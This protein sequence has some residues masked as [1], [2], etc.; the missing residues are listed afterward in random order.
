M[1][2]ALGLGLPPLHAVAAGT[3]PDER[4]IAAVIEAIQHSNL[5]AVKQ[6]TAGWDAEAINVETRGGKTLLHWTV[7]QCFVRGGYV[8]AG[9]KPPDLKQMRRDAGLILDYLLAQGADPGARDGRGYTP[10]LLA[11]QYAASGNDPG[12]SV[13]RKLKQQGGNANAV[14]YE[15][16]N[17]LHLYAQMSAQ[18]KLYNRV[19]EV[20]QAQGKATGPA[21][22]L[23]PAPAIEPI[24]STLLDMG[25]DINAANTRGQTPLM[26]AIQGAGQEIV[27][28][29]LEHGADAKS[30]DKQGMTTLHLL[31]GP[32]MSFLLASGD[33][34]RERQEIMELLL[35]AGADVNVKDRRGYTPL[36]YL[37]ESAMRMKKDYGEAKAAAKESADLPRLAEAIDAVRK[38]AR[39]LIRNGADPRVRIPN[40][41]DLTVAEAI[42]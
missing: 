19:L 33:A 37:A 25:A 18:Q 11:L 6:Q 15:E 10:M 38:L 21:P 8:Q 17:I 42:E 3:V 35:D 27:T 1:L 12:F 40:A 2:L 26:N 22:Q 20:R 24:L 29:L 41:R 7:E 5:A 23:P 32:S 34:G 14:D 30:V 9:G 13:A 31:A 36:A 16:N 28:A 39:F 4:A